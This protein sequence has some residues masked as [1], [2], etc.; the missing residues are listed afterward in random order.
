MQTVLG[1]EHGGMN[2]T[3]ADAYH[4]FGDVK[5]LDGAKR[6]DHLYEVNGM[7]G[8]T[9][10]YSRTFLN[11]Q[12]ANT[13]VPK[14]IGF[15][16]ISQ[17]QDGNTKL[18]T[19]ALNFW[20][21]VACNRTVCIGGNSVSEHF[22]AADRGSQYINNLDGPESCN[23]NNMLK[24][25]EMLFDDSHN[26][27]YADFYEQTMWN[28]ILSAQDPQT[29]GFV[30]FTSLRPQSYRIY[31]QVNQ[32]MWC[33]VGTGMENH[34]KYGHFVYTHDGDKT[35]YVNLFTASQLDNET[36]GISQET[37]F[38]YEQKTKLTVTKDGTYALAVRHPAWVGKDFKV[39]VN[40]EPQTVAVSEGTASY[41]TVSRSWKK[42]DVVT[43]DLPMS[44]RY[45]ECPNY[46]DYIA[47]KYGPI[48][49]AA[50][51]T[52]SSEE[53][54]AETGLVHETLQNEYGGE[55]RM[56]HAP[57]SRA[58]LKTLSSSSLLIGNRSEV[59]SRIKAKDLSNLTFDIDCRKD[60]SA[61]A[62]ESA[63]M[64]TQSR[65]MLQPFYSIHHA[66]Y[67]CYWYQQTQENYAQSDMGKQ[68]AEE[69]ALLER[70]LDFVATGEQQSEAGHEASY[71]EGST[72]GYYNGETY[73]D[74]KK[75]GFIQY[76]L[77]NTGG[78]TENIS[79]MCRFTVADKGRT[80]TIYI[81][82]TKIANVTIPA[83]H[84]NANENGFYNI[85]YPIPAELMTNGD[86]TAKKSVVF[87]IVASGSTLCPGLYYLRLLRD[88]KDKSYTFR[89]TDWVTGDAN[90]IQQ[91]N[92]SYDTE[93][94]TI[95]L[96]AG[97]GANNVCLQ[98]NTAD[99][100]YTVKADQKFLLV[101]GTNL[102]TTSGASYLWW[103]NGVNKGSQVVPTTT[104]T[105]TV[106]GEKAT[107]IAWDMTKSG[108]AG[109]NSC[110][111]FSV[112]QGM[113]I[114]GLT[115]TT[116][117]S[118]ISYIGFESSVDDYLATTGITSVS[119]AGNATSHGV[120]TIQGVKLNSD[121]K[122]NIATDNM[123]NGIYIVDGKKVVKR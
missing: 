107:V 34:S 28:H 31:S 14:F 66:R 32:A 94:N 9:E 114:F 29:G 112:C 78:E 7:Q 45:E 55:G 40:G 115:S 51:T 68:D 71:S 18:N 82:D 118:T 21:D 93:K 58:S 108:L 39:A 100:D 72:S 99:N 109:N 2:E 73:R 50:K 10:S 46:T 42:G 57:G 86:G 120:Y 43:V 63:T 56:D 5:Y 113:T 49:L 88:Y 48:L 91:S 25:S 116:G 79:V 70:T 65:L 103:L 110:D 98:L 85:E 105:I 8:T 97:K 23:A 122:D 19:A 87:K 15:E 24:L 83:S 4:I 61:P 67:S 96:N 75:G 53:E 17:L 36:F 69:A 102:K 1:W 104:K 35:L 119:T 92:I 16:R 27:K 123:P 13:Q 60:V 12:H 81:D 26:A 20:D 6:Y 74:A 111:P 76:T 52:A 77:A 90:R 95:T 84:K 41:V 59:L 11:G 22:L 101:Q 64:G 44:L 30:Y 38:P 33:C 54:A 117:T 80:A 47:F 89:A 37:E 121:T 106:D 3:L 62:D